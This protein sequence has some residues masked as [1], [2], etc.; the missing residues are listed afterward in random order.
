[1][2]T[3]SAQRSLGSMTLAFQSFIIFF[4]M[5]AAFGL[6]VADG[7]TVWITGLTLSIVA[8][9]LPGVLGKK[10]SYGFGWG[11]QVFIL[12][13]SIFTIFFHWLGYVFLVFS[14]IFAGLWAWAMLA[15]KTIDTAN[16]VL[17]NLNNQEK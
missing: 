13:L 17:E 11:F 10:G 14:M 15:G 5:L 12:A 16:R 4:G 7:S 6:K 1:M 9:A 2:K 8:I 3:R